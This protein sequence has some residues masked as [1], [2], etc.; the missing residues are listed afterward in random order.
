MPYCCWFLDDL[1]AYFFACVDSWSGAI[2]DVSRIYEEVVEF[3]KGPL[4][5]FCSWKHGNYPRKH[6]YNLALFGP[7][8]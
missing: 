1:L 7:F 6:G 3:V 8:G 4:W 5:L 2:V